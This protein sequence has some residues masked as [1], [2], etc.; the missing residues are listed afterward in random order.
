MRI[1]D[2]TAEGELTMGVTCDSIRAGA[3][4]LVALAWLG[5]PAAAEAPGRR[6]ERRDGE[7]AA[8]GRGRAPRSDAPPPRPRPP[9]L[10]PRRRR[11]PPRPR[12]D[13]QTAAALTRRP[14]RARRRRRQGEPDRRRR[15]AR[16][17]SWRSARSTPRAV[18][19]RSGSTGMASIRERPGRRSPASNAPTR[20]ALDL[21][22]FALAEGP[23]ADATPRAARRGRD[24]RSRRPSSPMRCRRADRASCRPASRR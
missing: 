18:S 4:A 19:R 21:S 16:R 13:P 12:V 11:T 7:R 6:A 24:E 15:L 20:T 1:A 14:R 22:A 5:G 10:R 23:A 2:G 3:V 17:P 9:R 8:A